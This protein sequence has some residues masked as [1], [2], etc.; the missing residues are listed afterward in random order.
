MLAV[1]LVVPVG[2]DHEALRSV[3]SAAQHAQRV[4]GRLVGPVDVL[5]HAHRRTGQLRQERPRDRTR[6]GSL[7]EH[8]GE[9]TSRLRREVDERAERRRRREVLARPPQDG[10]ARPRLERAYEGGLADPGLAADEHEPPSGVS[11]RVEHVQQLVSL[12]ERRHA[13]MFCA[14]PASFKAIALLRPTGVPSAD[15][16]RDGGAH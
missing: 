2:G 16:G 12:E 15:G 7:G 13:D 9:S 4:E 10:Q 1:D 8:G 14:R 5:D 11:R 3:D 6:L